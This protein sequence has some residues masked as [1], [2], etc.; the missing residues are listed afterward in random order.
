[1]NKIFG[2]KVDAKGNEY[3]F[4]FSNKDQYYSDKLTNMFENTKVTVFNITSKQPNAYTLIGNPLIYQN[5]FFIKF[6][7]I[8]QLILPFT[9]YFILIKFIFQII[10]IIRKQIEYSSNN[11]KLLFNPSTKKFSFPI[12][13]MTIFISSSLKDILDNNENEIIAVLLHEVGHNIQMLDNILSKIVTVGTVTVLGTYN[14]IDLL[15]W[16]YDYLYKY[17]KNTDTIPKAIR[18]YYIFK[19]NNG[20]YTNSMLNSFYFLVAKTIFLCFICSF[21][22]TIITRKMEIGADEMAIKLGYGNNLYEA[23]HKLHKYNLFMDLGKT[24]LKIKGFNIVDFCF[25]IT[26]IILMWLIQLSGILK[27]L[28]YPDPFTREKLIKEKIKVY[29]ISD[30]NIDRTDNIKLDNTIKNQYLNF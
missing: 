22:I 19:I 21:I 16:S 3:V 29:D 13:D 28:G 26:K 8:L 11:G 17:W 12:S 1:M 7:N 2:K 14:F 5:L 25:Y 4:N 18:D 30:K 27:V 6:Y 9:I 15:K 10:A 23:I 24:S 20:E